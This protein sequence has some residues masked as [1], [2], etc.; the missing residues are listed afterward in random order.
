MTEEQK[1]R[2]RSTFGKAERIPEILGLAFY[3][4]LFELDPTLR[5]L[6]R[7]DI[8]EQSRKLMATLKMAVDSMEQPKEILAA[9]QSLGRRH[10]QYGVKEQ[11]YDTVGTALVWALEQTL[12]SKFDTA[13]REAWLELYGWL[14]KVMK[15]AASAA[16]K[17]FDTSRFFARTP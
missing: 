7:H 6:F 15:E 8:Q 17:G 9:I 4:R 1:Q 13:A 10:I 3:R 12:G 5:P 16:E 11:H 14:A 2:V